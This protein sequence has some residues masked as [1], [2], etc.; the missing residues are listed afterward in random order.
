MTSDIV[1]RVRDAGVVGAGGAGFPTHVKLNARVDTVIGNGAACEPLLTCDQGIMAARAAE[2]VA[3][4][5][6]AM[7]ATGATT[8]IIALKAEYRDAVTALRRELSR[9]SPG[10][11]IRLHFL[12]PVYPAGDEHVLVYEVTRRLVP[13]AGIPLNVG[14][15][16][17]NVGTLTQ[18]AAAV[19]GSRH[20]SLAH[21]RR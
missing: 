20:P 10:P 5:R 8:G 6:L 13:E 1:G 7:E 15:V 14:V 19:R 18:I 16:V 9:T 12:A 21:G 2:V 11:Q 3:G 17:Q 4:L